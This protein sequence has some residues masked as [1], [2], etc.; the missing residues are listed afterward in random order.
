MW[1]Q[2]WKTFNHTL[3]T[4]TQKS[5]LFPVLFKRD[6]QTGV[7]CIIGVFISR[8]GEASK[9][10]V[11]FTGWYENKTASNS[12]KENTTFDYKENMLCPNLENL[13]PTSAKEDMLSNTQ[14]SGFLF[15]NISN[16]IWTRRLKN[17]G[18]F[19]FILI[20]KIKEALF[21]SQCKSFDNLKLWIIV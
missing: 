16:Q 8:F 6:V 17:A 15:S 5:L 7:Q 10:L 9:K 4:L 11:F 13:S 2:K 1:S 14:R 18:T 3:W 21:S 19:T 12:W 20:C